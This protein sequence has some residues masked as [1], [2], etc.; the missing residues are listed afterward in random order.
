MIIKFL[1]TPIFV[2][3]IFSKT[4]FSYSPFQHVSVF[5]IQHETFCCRKSFYILPWNAGG[6]HYATPSL[7]KVMLKRAR[8]VECWSKYVFVRRQMEGSMICFHWDRDR[9]SGLDFATLPPSHLLTLSPPTLSLPDSGDIT[10]RISL[11]TVFFIISLT[12]IKHYHKQ[13]Q[14]SYQILFLF[15]VWNKLTLWIVTFLRVLKTIEEISHQLFTF[16]L[17]SV[18][19]LGA[20]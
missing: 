1:K 8:R 3:Y 16:L 11:T 17:S 6:V 5:D 7:L 19:L 2:P 18:D 14:F 12:L 13:W 9:N 10:I 20:N 4:F 15:F